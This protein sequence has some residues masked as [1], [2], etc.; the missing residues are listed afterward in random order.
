MPG[1]AVASFAFGTNELYEFIDHNPDVYFMPFT[2]VNNPYTIAQNDN[3]ISVNTA[4]SIDL[5]GQVTAES[6]G[7]HQHCQ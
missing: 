6:M 2:K 7:Y 3:M 4:M 5:F 1:K